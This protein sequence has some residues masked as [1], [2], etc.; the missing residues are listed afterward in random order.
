MSAEESVFVGDHPEVDIMGAKGAGL[1][2]ILRCNPFWTNSSDADM[3]IDE[4]NEIP[5]VLQQFR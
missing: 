1:K 2:A 3:T 4:L 5:I